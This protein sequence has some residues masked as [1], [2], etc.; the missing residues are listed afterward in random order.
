MNLWQGPSRRF[1][2]VKVGFALFTGMV[3]HMPTTVWT[4]VQKGPR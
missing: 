1:A 3:G 2:Q 4:G